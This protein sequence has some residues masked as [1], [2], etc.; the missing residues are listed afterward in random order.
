[1]SH[2]RQRRACYPDH[3]AVLGGG[4][5]A[6]VVIEVL[7]GLLP[8][9]VTVSVH[10]PKNADSML[11]WARGLGRRIDVSS[12]WPWFHEHRSIAVIVVAAARD[13]EAAAK[14]ALSVG[15]PVLVEKPIAL[16]AA[17]ARR[18]ADLARRR[19]ARFGAAHVFLFA[20]YLDHFAKRVADAGQIRSLRV[21]WTDPCHEDRYGETKKYDSSLPIVSDILPHVLSMIGKLTPMRPDHCRIVELRRGGAA[22]ELTLMLGE[23]PCSILLERDS[24][25]RRRSLA[26]TVEQKT[27]HL[28]FS[29]EP[30]TISDGNTTVAGDPDWEIQ[31]RPM[32]QMLTA[33]LKWVANGEYDRRLDVDIGLQACDVIDRTMDEYRPAMK[34]WLRHRL[35]SM[36]QVDDDLRYALTEI[37]QYEGSLSAADLQGQI[38]RIQQQLCRT[39]FQGCGN[40]KAEIDR[41]LDFCRAS[42]A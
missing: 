6:R 36:E 29:K 30:G 38:D 5:W 22:V 39:N 19:N 37:L 25:Q 10:S 21:V 9:S 31:Q 14:H 23:I 27:L 4:R 35:S 20:S 24:D 1:M 7:C 18:L 32:A 11:V 3:V 34:S 16:T 33:F 2:E 8:S 26:A 12:A 42:S 41:L 15:V 28:E 13:H 17:A 40:R